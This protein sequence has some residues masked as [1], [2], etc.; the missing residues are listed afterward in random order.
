MRTF[1]G[2]AS[3]L[4][5]VEQLT[6]EDKAGEPDNGVPP[7][8]STEPEP[9]REISAGLLEVDHQFYFADEPVRV[10]FT[11]SRADYQA[12]LDRPDTMELN[13][14]SHAEWLRKYYRRWLEWEEQS[15]ALDAALV[16]LRVVR[17]DL[18]L[19]NAEYAELLTAYVQ[20]R[21]YDYV[22]FR[23]G[24][25]VKRYPVTML[26]EGIGTCEE[27]SMLLGGLL[28]KEGYHACLILLEDD[29]HMAVGIRSDV[30]TYKGEPY[31]FI[32]AVGTTSYDSEGAAQQPI[33][34]GQS[35]DYVSKPLIITLVNDGTRYQPR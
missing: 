24:E 12:S 27:K 29:D 5:Q 28:A 11:I 26:V 10:R 32:D 33:P 23:T 4:E 2:A 30:L 31:A 21:P 13:G 25:G 16:A 17:Q 19:D 8:T 22:K 1:G 15:R 14:E 3:R 34:I 18:A 35:Y 20:T 9:A 6:L 7:T